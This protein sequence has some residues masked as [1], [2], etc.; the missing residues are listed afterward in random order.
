MGEYSIK[1]LSR[2]V[3]KSQQSLYKLLRKNPEFAEIVAKNSREG[4]NR[5]KIYLYPCLEW[6]TEH[7][8]LE[9]IPDDAEET[10]L[11]DDALYY[12]SKYRKLKQRVKELK[13]ELEQVK[14]DKDRLLT[15]LE[16]EQQQRQGLLMTIVAD[17]EEKRL[18][19]PAKKRIS[20]FGKQRS[21]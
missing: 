18:L 2:L 1:D 3:G 7:Y 21:K 16:N 9:P 8:K 17:R 5:A 14:K 12:R 13:A 11:D 4:A 19:A 20:L 10:E 15:L 6:L